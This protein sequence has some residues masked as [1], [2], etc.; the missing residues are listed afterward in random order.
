M[1]LYPDKAVLVN[2]L[3]S[4]SLFN[5]AEA[6]VLSHLA[7]KTSVYSYPAHQRIISKGEIGNSMYMILSG[8]LKVHDKEHQVAE[9]KSGEYFGELS[10]L[11]SEPRSM[12][13][14]TTE[15]SMLGTINRSDFY[16]VLKEFPDM[17]REIIDVLNKRLRNQ[18]A[19]LIG[20]FKSRE[21]KLK[22]LVRIRTAEVM[23]QKQELEIKNAVIAE[24]NKE[25]TDSLNYAKRL[26]A[27]I[28][29]KK[30]VF[31]KSFEQSFILYMPKDIVS[32]DFYSFEKLD[33]KTIVAAAD[34]TGHGVGGAIM[35]MIGSSLLKQIIIEKKISS[36]A[37]IL[38]QLNLGVIEALKQE[39]NDTHDGMDVAICTFGA[40]KRQF[41]FAGANRPLWLVRNGSV[42]V[43][44]SDK[45]PIGG[46]QVEH[47][48]PF[49]NHSITLQPDDTIYIFSDGYAD[50]FGGPQGKK[51]MTKKLKEILLSFQN[52]S[53]PE[54]GKH[55]H[56]YIL[57]WMG[58]TVDQVDDMMIIGILV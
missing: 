55:L 4:I 33:D 15:P 16:E 12:S 3:G 8:R 10:L 2:F 24:K 11:D 51:L 35:S 28:L 43:F 48:V 40:D 23:Q 31:S 7:E 58:E 39:E 25:M 52:L 30:E 42:Q 45:F 29:P 46:T 6:A 20:E 1:E 38:S 14:T 47:S 26:Q 44:A 57:D 27:A 36:P 9:L 56:Q 53:M 19:I 34:C 22:E 50:Q 21:E 18:N 5:K 32:G 49:T 17:T 54:Q 37:E 13:V 41:T